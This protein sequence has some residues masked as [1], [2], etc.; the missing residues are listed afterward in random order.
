MSKIIEAR[1]ILSASDKTGDTFDK[2]ASKFRNVEKTAKALEGV[3]FSGM[4]DDL[5]KQ[6][7]RLRVAEKDIAAISKEYGNFYE[8]VF[9]GP[10]DRRPSIMF[11]PN[12]QHN[13][14]LRQWRTQVV[15]H[16]QAIA[17]AQDDATKS[18]RRFFATAGAAA[19]R[20]GLLAGGVG[21]T[22][23]LANRAARFT[24]D[25]T[26]ELSRE[27]TKQR[28]AGLTQAQSDAISEEADRQSALYPSVSR[29]EF[30][31]AGREATMQLG[32]AEAG[33][34]MMPTLGRFMTSGKVLWGSDRID[35]QMRKALQVIDARQ[36]TD[37]A[38]A[39]NLLDALLRASQVEGG[40]D[41]SAA[42][43]RSAIRYGRDMTRGQSD[44]FIA[45]VLP[46][47]GVDMGFTQAGTGLASMHSALIGG[48]QKKEADAFQRAVGLRNDTGL[49]G[50][51]V[52]AR[53]VDKWFDDYFIPALKKANVDTTDPAAVA[54][55]NAKFFSNRTAADVAGN[56]VSGQAQRMRRREQQE[57]ATGMSGAE[58]LHRQDVGVALE[59]VST[60]LA[61]LASNAKL[62]ESSIGTLNSIM[63]ALQKFEST[64]AAAAM[65]EGVRNNV[66]DILNSIEDWT[67]LFGRINSAFDRFKADPFGMLPSSENRNPR[68]GYKP[69]DAQWPSSAAPIP[70]LASTGNAT[71]VPAEG[72]W[73][74]G[75]PRTGG[76]RMLAPPS[77]PAPG[78]T[79]TMTYGTGA[80]QVTAQ[81]TGE[82]HGTGKFDINVNAGSSLIEVVRRAEAVIAL[83]GHI[84]SNGPGS[85]GKSSPDAAAPSN[86]RPDSTWNMAP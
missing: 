80:G 46:S 47:L 33:L 5:E 37:P 32:N 9:A 72:R 16:Y 59:A 24:F 30:R 13:R 15:G 39:S 40:A 11:D 68:S 56:L 19:L 4:G 63:G 60:Q 77:F 67:A 50:Q 57:R 64:G 75:N 41:Y 52:F 84:S 83:A 23:Y 58:N 48:R 28:Q 53:D 76:N 42:D 86:P 85:T 74:S 65:A 69:D 14:M 43:L 3:R 51:G 71:Y 35:E 81:V 22:A 20:W 55:F 8:K 7:R 6:L 10:R 61:N 21:S 70:F 26:K 17:D 29:T 44:R 1:A 2:L 62:A 12:S 27:S 79:D 45:S 49:V 54:A 18:G 36:I 82:V 66:Q 31:A 38:R 34:A 25:K 78:V 73:V